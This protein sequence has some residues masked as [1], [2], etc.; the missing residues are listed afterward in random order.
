MKA[1]TLASM[2]LLCG[3]SGGCLAEDSNM[4]ATQ[5]AK[6]DLS[7]SVIRLAEKQKTCDESAIVLEPAPFRNA[8][9]TKDQLRTALS[10]FYLKASIQCSFQEASAVVTNLSA[11]TLL[12]PGAHQEASQAA[13]LFTQDLVKLWESEEKYMGIEASKRH[14][15][16]Q[17]V[18]L[19]TPIKMIESAKR[20]GL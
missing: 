18:D 19:H 20:L 11:L 4:N 8:G 12:Q 17:S 1:K 7:T 13:E 9:L 10:Y 6:S 15:I 5:I 16:E 14:S 2:V 3:L